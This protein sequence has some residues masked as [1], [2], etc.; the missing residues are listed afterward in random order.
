[1]ALTVGQLAVELEANTR[2][3]RSALADADNRIGRLERQVNR[4]TQNIRGGFTGVGSSAQAAGRQISD[5]SQ[6]AT[7]SLLGIRPALAGLVAGVGLVAGALGTIGLAR[8]ATEGVRSAAAFE[9]TAISL[10]VLTGNAEGAAEVLRDVER[11]VTQTPF[12]LAEL[13]NTARSVAVIF[14]D[15]TD[16]VREFTGIAADLAAAFGRPVEQIGENLSRAF[17]AG[18]GAADVFR[19]AGIT[20]EILRIT[21]ATQVADVSSRD[22]ADALRQITAEGGKAA[23]AAAAAANSLGGALSNTDIALG[24]FQRTFGEALSPAL[25]D[26]LVNV[27]QPALMQLGELVRENSDVIADSFVATLVTAADAGASLI[28]TLAELTSFLGDV[29]VTASNVGTAFTI[30]QEILGAFFSAV[31]LGF[32]T[33][34]AAAFEFLA[35]I[36]G[37]PDRFRRI[38]DSFRSIENQAD[39]TLQGR[40]R[41]LRNRLEN[42]ARQVAQLQARG[43]QADAENI[44]LFTPRVRE[45]LAEI[46]AELARRNLTVQ[47]TVDPTQAR[48]DADAAFAD[49]QQAI[50]DAETDGTARLER[51]SAALAELRQGDPEGNRRAVEVLESLADRGAAVGDQLRELRERLAASAAASDENT[52]ATGRNTNAQGGNADAL[53][54]RTAAQERLL[55]ALTRDVERGRLGANLTGIRQEI[56]ALDEEIQNV[57]ELGVAEQDRALQAERVAQLTRERARLAGQ[58]ATAEQ[59]LPATIGAVNDQIEA[60]GRLDGTRAAEFAT[61][62]QAAIVNNAGDPVA[63]AAAIA[64]V[65]QDAREALEEI[66]PPIGDRLAQ[67]LGGAFRD[68][69]AGAEVDLA[70]RVG[71]TLYD[72]A[73][74]S[75]EQAFSDAVDD[76]G[77]LLNR[78][79]SSAGSALSGLFAGAE[80]EGGL[81]GGFFGSEAGKLLG[82]TAV[83][84]IGTGLQ[85]LARDDESSSSSGNIRSAVDSAERVRGI[86]AGPTQIAVAQVDR[87]ISDSFVETNSILTRQEQILRRIAARIGGPATSAESGGSSEATSILANEGASFA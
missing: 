47:L 40:A 48:T 68:A 73:S 56:A 75:L 4:A 37:I 46:E 44:D 58:L 69:A 54:R 51:L 8:F 27:V 19:E 39:E 62:L 11:L 72:S 67:T 24:N 14:G 64:Q 13:A 49:L 84:A 55:R 29:G 17:S 52:A 31:G 50:A 41:A 36:E 5:S 38:V 6:S 16:R 87:A 23:G 74:A 25:V 59:N 33:I 21:G 32:R 1:M 77:D 65:A 71:A 26:V 61:A 81:F 22:L 66:A 60:I 45:E 3:F 86:V 76:L 78:A 10:R 35:E 20:A 43:F 70:D 53:A 80:G 12:G 42:T 7:R 85:A 82:D 18:L 63:Q 79:L 83:A 2:Q 34:R 15:N 30:V 9:Q 57:E 28:G